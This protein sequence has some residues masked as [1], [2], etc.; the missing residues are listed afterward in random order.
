MTSDGVVSAL[1]RAGCVYAEDEARMLCDAAAGRADVLDRLV[2]RRCAGE[3]LEH[4]VGYAEL[5]GVR[6]AIR[7]GVFVPRRRSERLVRESAGLVARVADRPPV[8]V[9]LG[10]GSG[11]L[12]VALL[13]MA[14][15]GCVA[16]AIDSSPVAVDC[17]R[18]N[19]SGVGVQV[20]HGTGL[21]ALPSSVRGH[22]DVIMANL[23]YVPTAAI[24]LLP[25]EARLHEPRSTLDGGPDGL[26]PLGAA[27]ADAATWLRPD[28]HYV[29]E[30]HESQVAAATRLARRYGFDCVASSDP[31]D[32]T[33][34]I[35]LS[36]RR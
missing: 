26:I 2:A 20:V 15:A 22:V 24:A 10:C 36:I 17:A 9:D 30:L 1:R 33:A 27:L 11:A 23:P 31:E 35:D 28:G 8:V 32:G 29:G 18:T 3:P 7:P 19:L 6:I 13:R 14:P 12:L 16:Y 5:A 34:V 21:G 25:R 4:V